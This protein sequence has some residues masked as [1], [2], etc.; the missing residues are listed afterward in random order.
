MPSDEPGPDTEAPPTAIGD[1]TSLTAAQNKQ[2]GLILS[3]CSIAAGLVGFGV[4][5]TGMLASFVGI[6]LGV[7]AFRQGRL[8]H[9][10]P[11]AVS[12]IAGILVSVLSIVYWV[13]VVLFES[14]H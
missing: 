9:Y 6:G 10:T 7:W 3:L 13:C 8:A 1:V 4:P 11:S 12:G 5:I 14:Y 2:P